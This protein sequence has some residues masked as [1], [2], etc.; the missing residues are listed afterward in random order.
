M[1]LAS[2]W[3]SHGAALVLDTLWSLLDF[4]AARRIAW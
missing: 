4:L 3:Y 1:K 2:P